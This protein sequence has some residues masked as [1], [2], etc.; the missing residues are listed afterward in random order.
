LIYQ[1]NSRWKKEVWRSAW[2][3]QRSDGAE[4]WTSYWRYWR[5]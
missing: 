2:C 3:R 4:Y 1:L 5:L